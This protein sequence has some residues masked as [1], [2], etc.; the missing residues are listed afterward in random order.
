MLFCDD[1]EK[2]AGDAC[3]SYFDT[4]SVLVGLIIAGFACDGLSLFAA[5]RRV[6]FR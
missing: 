2:D 3:C 6:S 5:Q 1:N 4:H